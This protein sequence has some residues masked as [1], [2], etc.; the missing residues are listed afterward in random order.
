LNEELGTSL[1][2]EMY[3]AVATQANLIATWK[4]NIPEKAGFP[5]FRKTNG[6]QAVFH[7]LK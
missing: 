6:K 5:I 4:Q 1:E 7:R 3:F 2:A